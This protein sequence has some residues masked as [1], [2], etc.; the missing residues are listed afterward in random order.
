MCDIARSEAVDDGALSAVPS[1]SDHRREEVG[2][3]ASCAS[4]VPSCMLGGACVDEPHTL[5]GLGVGRGAL[6][7]ARTRAATR[8]GCMTRGL[9]QTDLAVARE[10][11][12]F[13]T[14]DPSQARA[15]AS[16]RSC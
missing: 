12:T 2:V 7:R 11:E 13:D 10:G 1:S 6:R 8:C 14:L 3:A 16:D 15:H 5:S 9:R 4:Q